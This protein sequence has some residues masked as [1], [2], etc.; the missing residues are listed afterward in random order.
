MTCP[1]LV[2]MNDLSAAPIDDHSLC[3]FLNAQRFW[4]HLYAKDQSA[5]PI[6]IT[7]HRTPAYAAATVSTLDSSQAYIGRPTKRCRAEVVAK[8]GAETNPQ[9]TSLGYDSDD[10]GAALVQAAKEAEEKT[11]RSLAL[12]KEIV[13]VAVVPP[14]CSLTPTHP[15]TV[16]IIAEDN[17][18]SAP[19]APSR[20][21]RISF[22]SDD[23]I[24]MIVKTKPYMPRQERLYY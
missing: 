17:A 22:A 19:K 23:E 18:F 10:D 11:K 3:Y 2:A 1:P 24:E 9:I 6:T 13:G 7:L 4:R 21:R 14:S 16:S 8:T 5:T 15:L 12:A 20:G